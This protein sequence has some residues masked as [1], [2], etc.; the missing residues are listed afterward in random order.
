MLEWSKTWIPG[1]RKYWG[2]TG[3]SLSL[4]VFSIWSLQHGGF[5]VASF[6]IGWLTVPKE[7]VSI[8]TRVTARQ[9]LH[10]LLTSSVAWQHRFC[11]LLLGQQNQPIVKGRRVWLHLLIEEISKNLCICFK[12]T[13]PLEE[14]SECIC[15][16]DAWIYIFVCWSEQKTEKEICLVRSM[17]EE[18][19]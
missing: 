6:I 12:A 1:N 3:M 14:V 18:W 7:H 4:C 16:Y 8:V 2:S 5:R 9:K 17:V 10:H 13:A 11:W 19:S 15:V